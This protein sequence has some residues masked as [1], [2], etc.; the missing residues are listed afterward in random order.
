MRKFSDEELAK[1]SSRELDQ[2][3]QWL[4]IYG[5]RKGYDEEYICKVEKAAA[6]AWFEEY[7]K[8]KHSI[9]IFLLEE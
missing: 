6:H 9:K 5:D 7:K 1:M 4:R 2:E 8:N 3:A